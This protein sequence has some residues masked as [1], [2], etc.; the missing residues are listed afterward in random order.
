MKVFVK[1]NFVPKINLVQLIMKKILLAFSGILIGS[2][3]A[4]A[5]QRIVLLEHFTQASCPPCASLNPP[6]TAL[7]D[8]NPDK[9]VAIKYQTSWPGTDPMNAANPTDVA[10]RVTYYGVSGVPNSVMEGNF[11]NGSPTG[12]TQAKID[13]RHALDATMNTSVVYNIIDNAAPTKDSILVTV[14]LN[15]LS[16]IPTGHVLHTAVIEREI[17]FATA[18]GTNGEKKFESVM[19]KMLPSASGTILPAMTAGQEATYTFKWAI[20]KVNGTLEFYNLGQVAAVAFVQNSA[21]KA[22]LNA[23][24]AEPKPWL[25]MAKGEDTKSAKIK[26]G[27][28]VS[29]NLNL[30]SKA[31]V[32]QNIRVKASVTSLPVGWT[33]QLAE[34]AN[35]FGD[36]ASIALPANTSK[37]VTVTVNGPNAGSLNKKIAINVEANSY[38]IYPSVKNTV[39]FTAIT[40]SEVLFVDHGGTGLSRFTQGFNSATMPFVALNAEESGDLDPDGFN[41]T[42]IKKFYYSTGSATSGNLTEEKA[43]LFTSYLNSGGKMFMMGQDIGYEVDRA[44][45]AVAG[46]FYAYYMGAEY[47]GDGATTSTTVSRIV[48]DVMLAPHFVGSATVSGSGSYP[49]QLAVSGSSANGIGFLK[50]ANENIA[51][52]YNEFENWK[53]IYVGFRMEGLSTTGTGLVYR[54]ALIKKSGEWFDGILTSNEFTKEMQSL[55]PA[56]PNPASKKL[57]VPVASGKGNIVITNISGKVVKNEEV[58]SAETNVQVLDTENLKSG[59]YFL[60]TQIGGKK[61]EVQKI[62]IE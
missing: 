50:Y 30:T 2:Y 12:V 46:D 23:G 17:E 32:D 13:Q 22:I 59:L 15:A 24:Y 20:T 52:I 4:F 43:N 39:K 38:T 19:R 34:G 44:G 26:S 9:I 51:A 7:L 28:V 56:F 27:D 47:V 42:N 14:K 40:P 3:C 29:Y 53:L 16:T 37:T 35:T 49:D 45:N 41:L 60:H 5:Q 21:T 61:S 48:D 36:T 18:P 58:S 62:V 33:L 11:Y 10:T 6:L 8:Q 57:F 1:P 54:N 31:S 25:A 55:S